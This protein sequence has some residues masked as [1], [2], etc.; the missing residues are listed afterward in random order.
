M[1]SSPSARILTAVLNSN[2]SEHPCSAQPQSSP[3]VS[4][5]RISLQ[6]QPMSIPAMPRRRVS[7]QCPATQYP[8][9][10][11]PQRILCRR[12]TAEYPCSDRQQPQSIPAAAN[13]AMSLQCATA[14]YPCSAQPPSISAVPNHQVSIQ[15]PT[16]KYPCSAQ[17]CHQDS[18]GWSR[19]TLH[20]HHNNSFRV[21]MLE[22]H[23]FFRE[24]RRVPWR[25]TEKS[26]QHHA[27][28]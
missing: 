16:T 24:P 5:R 28:S 4:H 14:E 3:A 11:Q 17:P 6:C 23:I 15:C 10:A 25:M 8:C 20:V 2:V 26:K 13:S 27:L 21:G 9:S 7:L 18:L 22:V 12:P 19:A 1:L